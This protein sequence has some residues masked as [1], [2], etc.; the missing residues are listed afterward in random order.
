MPTV[1]SQ[2][3]PPAEPN[4]NGGFPNRTPEDLKFAAA[5]AAKETQLRYAEAARI[6]AE[7][8]KEMEGMNCPLS[9]GDSDRK[10]EA[11]KRLLCGG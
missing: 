2:F 1:D 10:R 11:I 8:K 9:D 6:L 7:N 3:Y 5:I 4:G